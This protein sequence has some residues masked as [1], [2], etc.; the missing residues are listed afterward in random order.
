MGRAEV[1]KG[2]VWYGRA[3]YG[4]VGK[5]RERGCVVAGDKYRSLLRGLRVGIQ[6][7]ASRVEEVQFHAMVEMW[8][9]GQETPHQ[10]SP[11][12]SK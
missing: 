7:E 6:E 11:G 2:R 12:C 9:I 8:K 5:G 3:M 1:G 10:K 4:R